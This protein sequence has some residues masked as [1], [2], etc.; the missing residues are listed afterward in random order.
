MNQLTLTIRPNDEVTLKE[1]FEDYCRN[2]IGKSIIKRVSFNRANACKDPQYFLRYDD[3]L[4]FRG[5]T[6]VVTMTTKKHRV[7]NNGEYYGTF[8]YITVM[9]RSG[10]SFECPIEFINKNCCLRRDH[11]RLSMTNK[12]LICE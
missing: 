2:I 5:K 6:V 9:D 8:C 11:R 3:M 7:D 10:N 4:L 1:R 12:H